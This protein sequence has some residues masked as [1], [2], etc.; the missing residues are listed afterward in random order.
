LIEEGKWTLLQTEQAKK[1]PRFTPFYISQTMNKSGSHKYEK[2]ENEKRTK[3][4][5]SREKISKYIQSNKRKKNFL[6]QRSS[7]RCSSQKKNRKWQ[8]NTWK[9]KANEQKRGKNRLSR[10]ATDREDCE[11]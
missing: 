4:I 1:Q 9:E 6:A 8:N 10:E 2:R 7:N 3:L 11:R 5:G